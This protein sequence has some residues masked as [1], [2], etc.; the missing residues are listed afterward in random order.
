MS[1]FDLVLNGDDDATQQHELGS[2]SDFP[3]FTDTSV[4]I[5][6]NEEITVSRSKKIIEQQLEIIYSVTR[7]HG[8]KHMTAMNSNGIS[9]S[10]K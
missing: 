3:S 7:S 8:N 2:H 6:Q 10:K 9:L 4:P 1:F 5:A